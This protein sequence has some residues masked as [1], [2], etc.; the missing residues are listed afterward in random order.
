MERI[1]GEAETHSRGRAVDSKMHL[2]AGGGGGGG[3]GGG[4]SAGQG[5]LGGRAAEAATRVGGAV[6]DRLSRVGDA[7]DRRTGVLR[8]IRDHPL[9]ALGIA[10]S[11]GFIV[12]ALS[13]TT[14]RHWMVERGR[15]RVRT[16]IL[17]GV[18]AALAQEL[19]SVLGADEGLGQ[20]VQSLLHGDDGE[21]NADLYD[22]DDLEV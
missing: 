4:E 17:S 6:G 10:F 5:G 2:H 13:E 11:T 9:S 18:T 3:A 21:E 15:R 7:I 22:D 8:T 1:H 14:E 12:A 16:L 19:R 20:L